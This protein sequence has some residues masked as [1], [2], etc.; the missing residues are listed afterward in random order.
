MTWWTR[1]LL[2]WAKGRVTIPTRQDVDAQG[3]WE[4]DRRALTP[5]FANGK[6]TP[7]NDGDHQARPEKSIVTKTSDRSC[8]TARLIQ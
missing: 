5:L 4:A 7:R 6:P 1:P 3:R 8:G 2:D